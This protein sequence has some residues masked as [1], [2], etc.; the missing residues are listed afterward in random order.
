VES[1]PSDL[2]D[3]L[4]ELAGGIVGRIG[5]C[6]YFID[7]MDLC[8]ENRVYNVAEFIDSCMVRNDMVGRIVWARDALL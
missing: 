7:Q 8:V 3:C 2:V 4:E 6:T 5:G 1:S